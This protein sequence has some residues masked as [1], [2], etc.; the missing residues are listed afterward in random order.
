MA[1]IKRILYIVQI[2]L[3]DLRT[4]TVQNGSV[5]ADSTDGLLCGYREKSLMAGALN[6]LL[7]WR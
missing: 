6:Y 5:A 2:L 1:K 7:V 3:P 4:C